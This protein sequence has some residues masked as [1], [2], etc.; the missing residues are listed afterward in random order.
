VWGVNSE[1]GLPRADARRVGTAY[2]AAV[3]PSIAELSPALSAQAAADV[4]EAAMA[5]RAFDATLGGEIAPFAAVLLRSESAAS[6]QIENLSASARKIAEAE[7]GGTASEHARM[8]VANVHAMD[9]ALRMADH[10]DEAAVLA[11]HGALMAASDPDIAGRWRTDQV[12]IGGRAA[13]GPGT[14]HDADF[15]PPVAERV[16]AAMTDLMAFTRRDDMPVLAQVAIAHAHFETIHPFPDGN[17]RTGRALLHA[18][19]RAKGVTRHVSVP[20]SAGLLT[21]T[22]GYFAALTC[23]RD[24][25]MEPIVRGVARAALLGVASGQELVADLREIRASWD[26]ALTGLRSDAGARRLA[27]GL[28]RHPVIDAPLAREILAIRNNE[29]RHIEALV[30]RGI[31]IG[32]TDFKT[33]NR[34]WRAPQ[35]LHALDRYAE[36][37]G[38]RRLH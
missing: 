20:I 38:R 19:L 29:H 3:P 32:H 6:S 34:S 13:F 36:R 23:Y 18:L 30:E 9:A 14:P 10:L 7:L 27:D 21:D 2:R 28:L 25:D 31:L 22:A 12:W 1:S 24:G 16:P 15:V 4:E 17:G 37:G 35:I 8:I 26:D 5:L 11:M 33:R